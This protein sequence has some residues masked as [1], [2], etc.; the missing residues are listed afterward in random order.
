MTNEQ[1]TTCTLKRQNA[2]ASNEITG[3]RENGSNCKKDIELE[4]TKYLRMLSI[5]ASVNGYKYLKQA[6]ILY[7]D[8]KT[9]LKNEV[10]PKIA[11]ENH[12]NVKSINSAIKTSIESGWRKN[13]KDVVN[14]IFGNTISDKI[15]KPSNS[16]FIAMIADRIKTD[17]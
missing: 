15:Q 3:G 13:R 14:S 17:A 10:Y 11:E 16:E 8:G 5:P 12:V 1:K 4:I 2:K 7:M 6:I 9:S